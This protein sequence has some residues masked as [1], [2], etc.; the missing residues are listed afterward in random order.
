MNSSISEQACELLRLVSTKRPNKFSGVG[1]VFYKEL[2]LLPRV[3]LGNPETPLPHLP[4]FGLEKIAVTLA[5][6]AD[7]ENP[8]HDGF[9]LVDGSSWALTHVSQFISP[10]LPD[11]ERKIAE[12]RPTGARH[13]TALLASQIPSIFCVGLLTQAGEVCLFENGRQIH[14]H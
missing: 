12:P 5:A 13:M 7:Y 3:W 10:P 11:D 14:R 6:I 8:W 9:H 2:D 1:V 4:V